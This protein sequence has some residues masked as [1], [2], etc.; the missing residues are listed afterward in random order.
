MSKIATIHQP[1]FLSYLGFYD[2][3]SKAE[4]LV[5]ADSFQVKKNYF[6]NRNLIKTAQGTQYI[7][8]PIENH[9]HKS[10]R[11]VKVIHESRWQEKLLNAIKQNYSRTPYFDN[12]YPRLAEIINNKYT[13]LFDYNFEL[14]VQMLTWLGIK[15]PIIGF[16]SQLNLESTE[17]SDKCLEICQKV[18]ATTYLSGTSGKNYLNLQKFKEAN[19][20]VKIHEFFSP[21]YKQIYK[22]FINGLSAIDILMNQGEHTK[23][24]MKSKGIG[25]ME[26]ILKKIDYECMSILELFGGDGS[27][28]LSV[29][30]NNCLGLTI[31]ELNP[32]N[33]EELNKKYPNTKITNLDSLKIIQDTV[34]F[35]HFDML[36]IDHPATMNTNLILPQA[37]NLLND[38]G[39]IIFRA[40]KKPYKN[41]PQVNFD[42]SL[43]EWNK[44]I[45]NENYE[46]INS[47]EQPR[48]YYFNELWLS[49]YIF[50][51]RRKN[52]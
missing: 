51:L 6:D 26:L 8:I 20:E 34:W 23:E 27:G 35:N 49:N 32:K 29:Y 52:E 46:I 17:G 44:I 43:E 40:I 19:I 4:G 2:K 16:T 41:Y 15:T 5:I 28:E 38:E 10:F 48:E 9:N 36:I 21:V 18:G 39:I 33:Y 45:T 13:F 11:E 22:E 37:L 50:E 25:A 31:N 1:E 30:A 3:V 42:L 47:Y 24:I 7:G 14:L 12:Y